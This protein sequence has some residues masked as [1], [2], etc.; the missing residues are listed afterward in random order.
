MRLRLRPGNR[1]PDAAKSR[2]RTYAR[3][4]AWLGKRRENKAVGRSVRPDASRLSGQFTPKHSFDIPF[5]T[6]ANSK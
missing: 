6:F 1:R 4:L 5:L 2:H 3:R